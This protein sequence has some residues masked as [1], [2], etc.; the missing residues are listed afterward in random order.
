MI[1]A[2]AFRLNQ[3]R[4]CRCGAAG[5][6]EIS[7][8]R[9]RRG[10]HDGARLALVML[11]FVGIALG[12]GLRSGFGSLSAQAVA[13][14]VGIPSPT[15]AAQA[16]EAAV[17]A[18]D[19]RL[20]SSSNAS[21][22]H[23]PRVTTRGGSA[24]AHPSGSVVYQPVRA[25]VRF[26]HQAHSTRDTTCLSC[27]AQAATSRQVSDNL[28]PTEAACTACHAIDRSQPTRSAVTGQP[29]TACATC[30]PSWTMGAVISPT[31]LPPAAIHFSH[32]AHQQ[33]ACSDCHGTAAQLDA[34][35]GPRPGV[36]MAVCLS[37]H[38]NSAASATARLH[39]ATPTALT[40]GCAKCHWRSIA[41]PLQTNLPQG[42]LLPMSNTFGDAHVAGFA[43]DHRMAARQANR[44][45]EACH[46]ESECS[47]CHNG[48]VKPF[49]YHPG[50]YAAAHA[51]DAQ[52]GAQAC[53]TC[54]RVATFCVT[55]HER[56]GVG[57]R[58]GTLVDHVG[59]GG[60]VVGNR[61]HPSG[62]ASAGPGTNLHAQA[63]RRTLASCAS[64]HRENDCL[65]C[66]A[67]FG[68]GPRASPHP[69]GW[70]NSAT[71][72]TMVRKN[73]RLCLRC[74]VRE[75]ELNCGWSAGS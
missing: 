36:K 51:T 39:A 55:C 29:P 37:C 12:D 46:A 74:H 65:T 57:K 41:G 17:Q 47:D 31:W 23:R 53:Q 50:N 30:H 73:A 7:V 10:N 15:A 32:A 20:P 3:T 75:T 2:R 27:H 67:G 16:K 40:A 19:A 5:G 1:G 68:A 28:L 43:S 14:P 58:S 48:V 8:A 52:R 66:H 59:D 21:S 4:R 35:V 63:A 70:R 22:L 49:A 42:Q 69:R 24:P 25:A 71:C 44:T 54:H 9:P 64:C 56:V 72:Q 33:S 11:A 38:Q 18:K 6:A 34:V 45:C 26:S 61:V 13:Q 60:V 62:W